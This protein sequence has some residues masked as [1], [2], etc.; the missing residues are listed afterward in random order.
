MYKR[1]FYHSVFASIITIVTALI[2]NR[3]YFFATTIDYS[4]VVNTGSIIGMSVLA[5]FIAG[6]VEWALLKWLKGKGEIVF[7]FVFSIVSFAC[8]IIPISASL[9]LDVK[10]PELFPGLAVPLVFFPAMAW[11][12]ISHLFRYRG[13]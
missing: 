12:T 8:V 11:Y 3:F 10:S 6:F 13:E 4:K 2:Y 1:I 5:C 7:N 9:P